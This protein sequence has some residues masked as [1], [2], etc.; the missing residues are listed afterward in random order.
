MITYQMPQGVEH[1][2]QA[3][4]RSKNSAV[5]TYQMPQGV[6]HQK[7]VKTGSEELSV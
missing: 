5:I 7:A 4:D 3:T 2:M 6:E 1:Q